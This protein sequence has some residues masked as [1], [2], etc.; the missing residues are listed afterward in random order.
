MGH[1]PELVVLIGIALAIFG[2][3]ALNSMAR[4]AGKGVSQ[5]KNAKDK[6]MAELPMEEIAKV[7]ESIPQ[8]PLNPQQAVRMLLT[9]EQK[10]ALKKEQETKV[11]EKPAETKVEG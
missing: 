11:A 1:I 2:P 7:T 5:V 9:P 4:N 3:K 8:V 6:L 10:E